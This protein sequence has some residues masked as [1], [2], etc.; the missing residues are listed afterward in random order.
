MSN[1][2]GPELVKWLRK[3]S[4]S[5]LQSAGKAEEEGKREKLTETGRRLDAVADALGTLL[6]G[7]NPD[8]GIGQGARRVNAALRP[9]AR[10]RVVLAA[11]PAPLALRGTMNGMSRYSF[12]FTTDDGRRLIV[13]KHAVLYWQLEEAGETPASQGDG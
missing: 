12:L 3:Q 7:G 9:G 11:S 5:A 13:E 1:W 6:E 2:S 4:H 10:A 8:E